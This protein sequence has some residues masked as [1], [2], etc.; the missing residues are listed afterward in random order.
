M[1]KFDPDRPLTMAKFKTVFGHHL[2]VGTALAIVK[3]PAAA[4][5][6]DLV[7]AERLFASGL[8]V[9]SDEY[10]PTPV[11]TKE[12]EAARLMAKADADAAAATD[13]TPSASAAPSVVQD[14]LQTT[15]SELREIAAKEGVAVE[16]DDNKAELQR[17]IMEARAARGAAQ[18]EVGV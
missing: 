6:I 1:S 2:P 9:Y 10:L 7:M 16:S 3:E 4:G 18:L 17:K 5:E 15:N 11:E 8:A 13:G 12:A 14:D